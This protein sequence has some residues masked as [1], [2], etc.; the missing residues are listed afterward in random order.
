MAE[1][2]TGVAVTSIRELTRRMALRRSGFIKDEMTSNGFRAS[3]SS[4]L[5][6]AYGI[7]M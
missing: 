7:R 3:A 5:T 2:I 1:G 6:A 4:M